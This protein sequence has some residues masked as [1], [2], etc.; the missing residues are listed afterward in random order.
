MF[1][2]RTKKS[3]LTGLT[4]PLHVDFLRELLVGT[5]KAQ[6]CEYLCSSSLQ[7]TAKSQTVRLGIPIRFSLDIQASRLYL[8]S[9]EM[10]FLSLRHHHIHRNGTIEINKAA[11]DAIIRFWNFWTVGQKQKKGEYQ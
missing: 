3:G 1:L 11:I 2:K 10:Q 6:E 5:R 4:E 9:L 7:K 8:A